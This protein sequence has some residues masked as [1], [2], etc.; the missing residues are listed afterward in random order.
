MSPTEEPCDEPVEE[1]EDHSEVEAPVTLEVHSTRHTG[2]S[3]FGG[4]K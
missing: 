1:T 2:V 3:A 4:R